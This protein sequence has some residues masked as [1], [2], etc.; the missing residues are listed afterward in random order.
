MPDQKT[1]LKAVAKI[2]PE[3]ISKPIVSTNQMS[4]HFDW[5]YD[6]ACFLTFD[7]RFVFLSVSKSFA[8]L[9]EDSSYFWQWLCTRLMQE[10]L[11]YIQDEI[12]HNRTWKSL[13]K[14]LWEMRNCWSNAQLDE[15]P[16]LFRFSIDVAARFRPLVAGAG[17]DELTESVILPLHQRVS[18]VQA[19][20]PNLS[21]SQA[22]HM[23]MNQN[24]SI[25]Q[26]DEA[27]GS[28]DSAG[29]KTDPWASAEC[30]IK[31]A[32]ID[33]GS[34]LAIAVKGTEPEMPKR[35]TSGSQ[36][37]AS[38]LSV[39]SHNHGR[40]SNSHDQDPDLGSRTNPKVLTVAPGVGLREFSFD[41]VFDKFSCQE[42]VYKSASLLVADVLN[43]FNATLLVYGQTGS[44]KTYTMVG[45]LVNSFVR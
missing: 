39:N 32:T 11:L 10:K 35:S 27:S 33:R 13:F 24:K 28:A 45:W 7:E 6:T 43:G 2:R 40:S 38:I 44:G 20:N 15:V 34:P 17:G 30:L 5:F 31:D 41:T 12:P 3:K 21:K 9:A 37:T 1:K 19:A 16:K 29:S 42:D 8:E 18:L 36:M 22:L 23:I 25:V 4:E 14:D 26:T